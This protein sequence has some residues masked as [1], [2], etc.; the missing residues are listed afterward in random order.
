VRRHFVDELLKCYA[1]QKGCYKEALKQT[2]LQ[3]DKMLFSKEGKKELFD[4]AGAGIDIENIPGCTG[5]VALIVGNML[6]VGNAGDSRCL[7]VENNQAIQI[8]KDHVPT[9]PIENKRIKDA[10]SFV[11]RGRIGG[12]INMSRAI[13]DLEFKQ[14]YTLPLEKQ[15]MTS[16]PDVFERSL[17]S[18]SQMLI[19]GCDGVFDTATNKEVVTLLS[20]GIKGTGSMAK[21][22]EYLLEKLVRGEVSGKLL[23]MFFLDSRWSKYR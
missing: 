22:I 15:A 11:T 12:R 2:F 5:C 23:M 14:N 13:G 7:L 10:G 8:T 21:G 16:L 17:S 19:I 20:E 6:Y 4:I 9:D 3:M 1:F 18:M